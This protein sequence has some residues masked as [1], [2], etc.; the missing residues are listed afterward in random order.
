MFSGGQWPTSEPALP[1]CPVGDLQRDLLVQ[2]TAKLLGDWTGPVVV[3]FGGEPADSA[4]Y[5]PGVLVET[6]VPRE[7]IDPPRHWD[8]PPPWREGA[9]ARVLMHGTH[10]ERVPLTELYLDLSRAECRALCALRLHEHDKHTPDVSVPGWSLIRTGGGTL[11][12]GF[13]ANTCWPVTWRGGLDHGFRGLDPADPR[14]LPDGTRWVDAA[15]LRRLVVVYLLGGMS[16]TERIVMMAGGEPG[17]S[18]RLR[19]ALDRIATDA[20]QDGTAR[21]LVEEAL[22]LR[23]P[24]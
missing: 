24:G 1:R 9:D 11:A 23:D 12:W 7:P 22:G 2:A 15:A 17:W 6:R 21:R 5:V 10:F 14:R 8:R 16:F 13:D 18:E 19:E 20:D 3:H 4:D